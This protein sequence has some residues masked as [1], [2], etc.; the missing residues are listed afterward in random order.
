M[1]DTI[2]TL[3]ENPHKDPLDKLC[4]NSMRE[5]QNRFIQIYTVK[6]QRN[7]SNEESFRKTTS[8]V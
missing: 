7:G 6:L 2:V 1:Q 8:S 5:E 4:D 3:S